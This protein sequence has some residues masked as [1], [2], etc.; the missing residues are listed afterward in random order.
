MHQNADTLAIGRSNSFPTV[1]RRTRDGWVTLSD[2]AGSQPTPVADTATL[3]ILG[4][5]TP[6][7]TEDLASADNGAVVS[8]RTGFVFQKQHNQWWRLTATW[9]GDCSAVPTADI[10]ADEPTVRWAPTATG[11]A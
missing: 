4:S 6:A 10:A 11:R 7:T 9:T 5:G 8:T 1:A 3:T 2:Q